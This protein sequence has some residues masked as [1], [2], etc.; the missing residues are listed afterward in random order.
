[1]Y[2]VTS[3]C[4]MDLSRRAR[5]RISN[6]HTSTSTLDQ[7]TKSFNS[8]IFNMRFIIIAMA[9]IAA[10][11][12]V[13]MPNFLTMTKMCLA[14]TGAIATMYETAIVTSTTSL[15][16]CTNIGYA[17]SPGVEVLST[18]FRTITISDISSSATG[19]VTP[20]LTERMSVTS[21]ATEEDDSA[22][23]KIEDDVATPTDTEDD[24]P[25]P[26]DIDT[27]SD[28]EELPQINIDGLP[29]AMKD[30]SSVWETATDGVKSIWSSLT[31]EGASA[32]MSPVSESI[33]QDV[34]YSTVATLVE[35]GFPIT[36]TVFISPAATLTYAS[37]PSTSVPAHKSHRVSAIATAKLSNG[38]TITSM[39]GL[40]CML[41]VL[42]ASV[43]NLV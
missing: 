38:A 9:L 23:T 37:T 4:P 8:S 29:S 26:T 32:T 28:D 31:K 1:M 41:S 13:K 11:K 14:A 5:L 36:P 18:S 19:H 21:F 6:F 24:A 2:V 30:L 42:A 17:I 16:G 40:T 33:S 12:Q 10:S 27:D 43:F 34:I 7:I 20:T 15:I 35:P 25:S 22:P 39:V 3:E